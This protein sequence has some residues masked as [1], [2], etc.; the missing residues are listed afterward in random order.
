MA[1]LHLK[2]ALN[3]ER[4]ADEMIEEISKNWT[5]PFNAPVVIFPD[6]K[7]EQ[8][9]RL[10]WIKKKGAL[11]NLN[12]C[13]I[14][15]FLFDVLSGKDNS[16][17]KLNADMLCNVILAYLQQVDEATKKPNWQTLSD[18]VNRYLFGEGDPKP[19][20]QPDENRLF[21]FAT[22]MASLFLEYETSRP[23][24]FIGNE[25]GLLDRWAQDTNEDSLFFAESVH[26]E[27]IKAS[28]ETREMWQ[29]KLYS[30]I[31]HEK[32]GK[33]SLLT[34]VFN[35]EAD[36]KGSKKDY[37][38]IPYLYK[39]WKKTGNGE[40][41][42]KNIG[43]GKEG[44]PLPV[45]I[46]GLSGMG[47]FYRVILQKY[48][49]KHDVYAYIQNPCMEFWEDAK[50]DS[51]YSRT[52]KRSDVPETIQNRLNVQDYSGD[53]FDID[54]IKEENVSEENALLANW[55]RSGRDNIKLW[56]QATNYDFDFDAS[57]APKEGEELQQD[58]LLH[59]VQYS[60]A[61]RKKDFSGANLEEVFSKDSIKKET[62]T[63]N[64]D[65]ENK[66]AKPPQKEKKKVIESKSLTVKSA[67]TRIREIEYLHS[68]IC[69]L[70]QGDTRVEDILVVSPCLDDYRTAIKMVFDQTP[71]KLS[72]EEKKKNE[73]FLH[74][75]FA[76][77]DSPAKASLTENALSSLFDVLDKG[78]ISRPE[79]FSLVRNPVV[80]Q[81][82]GIS[83]DD[84]ADW[85]NWIVE[86]NTYR[87]RKLVGKNDWL[88]AVNRL[89]LSQM[90]RKNVKWSDCEDCFN[91]TKP[92][93]DIAS[94]DK[95][96][97]C[98]FVA[99]VKDLEK[100]IEDYKKPV[101][102]LDALTEALGKWIRMQKVPDSMKSESFVY[103]RVVGAI[104]QLRY[105]MDAGLS[106]IPLK[107]VA[108]SLLAGAEGTEY[109][110]GNLFVNGITF[111]KF[112]PNR[113][114]P[115]KHLFF[116]G[117]DS[118]SFPGAKRHNTLDL[119]KSCPPWPGDDSPIAKNRYAFLC[120]LMSASESFHMSYVGMD[121]KK[122]AELYPSSVVNDLQ[123]FV[124][125]ALKGTDFSWKTEEIPL[126]ETRD[127]FEIYTK[128]GL[129]NKVA[130]V[131]MAQSNSLNSADKE[132]IKTW[133]KNQKST[134]SNDLLTVVQP[135]ER[136]TFYKLVSFLKDPFIFRVDQILDNEESDNADEQPFEPISLN[137]LDKSKY[138]KALLA[139]ELSCEKK[140]IETE[141][142]LNGKLP[143][144]LFKEDIKKEMNEK[145]E[146]VLEKLKPELVNDIKSQW[147]YGEKIQDLRLER[148]GGTWLLSGSLD[149]CNSKKI[150]EI[151]KIIVITSSD[152][153]EQDKLM[154]PFIQ[155]LA[156]I[157]KRADIDNSLSD[158]RHSIKIIVYTSKAP[159]PRSCG[160]TKEIE[161]SYT[162]KRAKDK[163][164]EIYNEAFIG[165][166]GNPPFSKAVPVKI[167]DKNIPTISSYENALKG[168]NGQWEY[169]SK[170]D[171]FN[172]KRDVGFSP[173]D[174]SA[175]W[176]KA[177][178]KMKNLTKFKDE[179]ETIST[180][181]NTDGANS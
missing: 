149:W 180:E 73:G 163:L 98:R 140:N 97:L 2:F 175:E 13:S 5:D 58:S 33:D 83:D 167:L 20:D 88:H 30:A 80:Q 62:K 3:L 70:L 7:L 99:C 63:E 121:I 159:G 177:V 41:N 111:M 142:S 22:K 120:Q 154:S 128:K 59:C 112:V 161:V 135:P 49:E 176:E 133:R 170:K 162:S 28:V 42:L 77:V 113:T 122:D 76:I 146:N 36:R 65:P 129:R 46:F 153:V 126:D 91:E 12:N 179:D 14:D 16:C 75:R 115:V 96:S 151:N 44:K 51:S 23:K 139:E 100:W 87:N 55:G 72:K 84:V 68:D 85:E 26:N 94:S 90:T 102:D 29:R 143:D 45:F 21:D 147:S 1:M 132:K 108:Q 6:F 81:V 130:Y 92:F 4:L 10:K 61:H 53:T 35:K 66:A 123:K 9:F 157:A 138:L 43:T 19:T 165:T 27:N 131:N 103:Q 40:F 67:P 174:F 134:F 160:P 25:K 169:F 168:E 11:L 8:W 166:D 144:G 158:I 78:S 64:P 101:S 109:S 172:A 17:Q 110:C 150:E 141:F 124:S 105:Q 82:R 95:A 114:I 136:V 117:A 15:R 116:I 89:L 152:S 156:I 171:L 52:W 164:T 178:K 34:K 18:E 104:D 74:V 60:I 79:F 86:M 155:A 145:K 39:A 50:Q 32:N 56:C 173:K 119:R 54:D 148:D 118:T 38:T 31:F 181:E 71:V 107:I 106:E 37:Q 93:Y 24:D 125:E 57:A 127:A 47:Q 48:A 69:K 137:A